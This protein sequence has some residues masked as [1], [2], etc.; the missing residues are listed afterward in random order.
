M[1]SIPFVYNA[2]T[3][4]DCGNPNVEIF[5]SEGEYCC[6]CWANRTEPS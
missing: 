4:N 3:C 6:R 1:I 5:Q 2:P